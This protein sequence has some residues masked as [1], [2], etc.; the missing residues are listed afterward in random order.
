MLRIIRSKL[1]GEINV[2]AQSKAN[3]ALWKESEK[4]STYLMKTK[5]YFREKLMS[6]E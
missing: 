1:T 3:V 2:V 6:L 5:E 4:I